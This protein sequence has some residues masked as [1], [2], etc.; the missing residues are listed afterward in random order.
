MPR[1]KKGLPVLSEFVRRV[2]KLKGLTQ[3]DVQRIS[4]GRITDG[5]VASITV[6]RASNLS[7]AKLSALADGLGVDVDTL[8]Q[9]AS[10]VPSDK[11]RRTHTDDALTVLETVHK[12]VTSPDVCEIL[13]EAVR[14]SPEERIQ[15]LKSMKQLSKSK[16]TPK[17]K[18]PRKPAQ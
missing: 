1:T 9:I 12:A 15:L 5:Y 14:M 16:S 7:V 17:A 4:R 18:R 8:F 11:I 10:G 2:L 6:G 13:N 3:K